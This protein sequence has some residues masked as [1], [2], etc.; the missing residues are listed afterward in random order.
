MASIITLTLNPCLDLN[1]SVLHIQPEIKLRCSTPALYPGGGGIN[2]AR[3]LKNLGGEATAVFPAG[4][5]NG[6]MLENLLA[7]EGVP[8]KIVHTVFETRQNIIIG[9]LASKQ[10][11]RF[12]MP[13]AALE[14]RV[15]DELLSIIENEPE[16][17]FLIVSGSLPPGM[18]GQIFHRLADIAKKK[19]AKLVVDTSGEALKQALQA[20]VYMIKPS[21]H[22]LRS[23]SEKCTREKLV[24]EQAAELVDHGSCQVVVVSMGA[25]GALL[26]S[27]DGSIYK[28]APAVRAESTVGAGDSMVAGIVWSLHSGKSLEQAVEYGCLC[29]AAA[30]MHPGTAL[31]NAEDVRLLTRIS[32]QLHPAT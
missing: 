6:R 32:D 23:A 14:E 21:I 10:Q 11:Y 19:Q 18:S 16:L 25:A 12:N 30:T 22:E 26:V 5:Y 15:T 27:K 2:V 28:A 24:R 9:D 31:C 29:G 3:A 8:V 7:A 17:E 20:G 1:T 13:G 4:G